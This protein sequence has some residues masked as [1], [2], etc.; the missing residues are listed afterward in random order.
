MLTIKIT[1]NGKEYKSL[2]DAT[3]AAI[4]SGIKEMVTKKLKPYQ[5]EINRHGGTIEITASQDFKNLQVKV[6]GDLPEDLIE[7]CQK[8]L[9]SQKDPHSEDQ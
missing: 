4:I 8:A 6:T 7:R 5:D 2:K 9:R 1:H 3:N